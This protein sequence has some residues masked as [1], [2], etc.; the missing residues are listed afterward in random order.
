MNGGADVFK[1]AWPRDG[2]TDKNVEELI[3][4]IVGVPHD[5]YLLVD[6]LD[7]SFVPACT[8]LPSGSSYRLA[9]TPNSYFK[10]AELIQQQDENVCNSS[11]VGDSSPEHTTSATLSSMQEPLLHDVPGAIRTQTLIGNRLT[12]FERISSHLANERTLL[13]WI[14][15]TVSVVGLA[16]TFSDLF[17]RPGRQAVF[18]WAGSI[19]SWFVGITIFS[20]G[21]SRY[22]TVKTVLNMPKHA[23]SN[24]FGR[25]G[26]LFIILSFGI[27]LL[28]LSVAYVASL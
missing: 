8:A 16:V 7:G 14:R 3:G 23:I 6:L 2:T 21:V 15:T 13:A 5:Q 20:V 12:K 22:Q 28:V 27:L 25:T 17:A 18:Y 24:R 9:P 11:R 19:F 10:R 26:I 4:R 1:V